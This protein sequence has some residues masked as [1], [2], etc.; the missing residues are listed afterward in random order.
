MSTIQPI[1]QYELPLP[2]EFPLETHKTNN[3]CQPHDHRLQVY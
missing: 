3:S 2:T 1:F